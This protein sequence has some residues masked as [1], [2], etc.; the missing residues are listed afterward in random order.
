MN[1]ANVVTVLRIA[2]VPFFA[3]ALLVDDGQDVTWRLIATGVFVLAAATDRLD[4]YLARRL[5][6]VTDLG[7]LLDPIADKAL[8]G[9]GLIGLSVI[10]D[11]SWWVTVAILVRE[12]GITVMRFFLLRY[13]VLPASRG[14]KIKTVLQS[15]ALGA[16]LLPLG[17][18]PTWVT[19]VA[20]V[21]MGVAVVVTLVTGLDYVRTAVRVHRE[22]AAGAPPEATRHAAA[23]GTTSPHADGAGPGPDALT[24]PR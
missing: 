20:S 10:G 6:L 2:V 19:V 18:L 5:G 13:L 9:A 23:T 14:G 22:H 1:V 4:G 16:Y 17:H 24:S 21:L 12:L 15:V 8:I 11:L 7:K 3:W